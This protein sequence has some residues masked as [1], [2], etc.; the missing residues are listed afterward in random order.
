VNH[1]PLPLSS[2]PRINDCMGLVMGGDGSWISKRITL[3]CCDKL[4]RILCLRNRIGYKVHTTLALD[5][6][7]G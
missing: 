7:V 5:W 4:G 3:E 1:Y 2:D 6:K